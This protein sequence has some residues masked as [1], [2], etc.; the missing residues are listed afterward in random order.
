[1][2]SVTGHR[3]AEV[4]AGKF[5]KR[6]SGWKRTSKDAEQVIARVATVFGINNIR[7]AINST[8][9]RLVLFQLCYSCY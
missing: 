9:L 2:H 5:Q 1:M 6:L 3:Y 8:C 7:N 4:V